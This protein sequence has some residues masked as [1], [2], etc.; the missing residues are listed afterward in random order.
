MLKIAFS[1]LLGLLRLRKKVSMSP[2][3]FFM[4]PFAVV[5][6]SHVLSHTMDFVSFFFAQRKELL[7]APANFSPESGAIFGPVFTKKM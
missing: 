2:A 7:I 4:A 6:L 3:S 1:V 5:V